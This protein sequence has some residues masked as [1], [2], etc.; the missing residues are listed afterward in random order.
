[1][2]NC[3]VFGFHVAWGGAVS[4]ISS[5]TIMTF[6]DK[7]SSFLNLENEISSERTTAA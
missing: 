4:P 2:H 7:F 5:V 1:M 6:S 3:S